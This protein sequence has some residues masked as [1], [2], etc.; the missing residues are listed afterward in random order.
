MY[1]SKN[2]VFTHTDGEF[3][4]IPVGASAITQQLCGSWHLLVQ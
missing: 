4:P 2:A 1:D 3:G